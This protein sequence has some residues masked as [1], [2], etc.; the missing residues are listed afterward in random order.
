[1]AQ[2]LQSIAIQAP[3][4]YGLNTQ[5]SPTALSEQFALVADNCVIDQF[6]RVGARKGWRYITDTNAADIDRIF[7]YIKS[8]GT[9][10]I[11]S[12]GEQQGIQRHYHP[13]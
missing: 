6:G 5:D 7:E 9:T 13:Y 4:F 10:E 2:Q 3:G 11:V 12:T 8:D 1:M